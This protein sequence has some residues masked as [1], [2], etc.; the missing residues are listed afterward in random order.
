[1]FVQQQTGADQLLTAIAGIAID[2]SLALPVHLETNAAHP[3]F[4]WA[5]RSVCTQSSGWWKSG[6]Q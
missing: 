1:V 3:Y 4:V 6:G 2:N 5:C